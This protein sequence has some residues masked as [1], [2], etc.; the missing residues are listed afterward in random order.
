MKLDQFISQTLVSIVS[1]IQKANNESYENGL[2]EY[3]DPFEMRIY[4]EKQDDAQYI[5]FDVA[6]TT[7]S[8]VSGDV[9]GA[10]DIIVAS[11]D[12]NVSGKHS[13]ENITRVKFK[14]LNKLEPAQ[15]K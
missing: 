13:S 8:E 5:N 2:S 1:G 9:K 15:K 7:T 4:G 12:A 11:V 10:G 14:I 6:V 3:T